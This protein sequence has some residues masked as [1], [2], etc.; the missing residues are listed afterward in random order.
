M[1]LSFSVKTALGAL[2]LVAAPL[3]AAPPT[4][5]A[6]LSLSDE[7]VQPIP[8]PEP[9]NARQ[10]AIVALGERL[11]ADPRLSSNDTTA[12]VTCHPLLQGGADR[13]RYSRR[14]LGDPTPVNTPTIFNLSLNF[15]L[16][17]NGRVR[18]LEEQIR[19]AH[20]VDADTRWPQVF[21][22]LQRDAAYLQ[23]FA[24]LFADGLTIAN[25]Q[26]AIVAFEKSLITSNSRFDRYLRGDTNA[27]TA[28]EAQGYDLFKTYGCAACHQGANVGG[29]L[30]QKFG[31]MGDYFKDRGNVTQ[32][33]VGRYN[34][35][36]H[37]D[38]RYVFRVPSLRLAVLTPPYL[39][40]GSA[41]TLHDAVKIMA[42]YQLGRPISDEHIELII[43]FLQ[44]LP[45][46]Y[47][48]NLLQAP[49]KDRG[50]P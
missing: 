44:T 24:M 8:I 13:Q 37:E 20:L 18:T 21:E 35:T 46:E 45:G 1:P 28:R 4:A 12:C 42:K 32:A 38:D 2:L 10:R 33:D 29:N 14:A 22:K 34:V 30:F 47:Q 9:L 7:P 19:T 41:A 17:W 11:F 48:G 6:M 15:R 31:V 39:H 27:I 5:P 3:L 16:F 26:D 50:E 36:G 40:D 25:I 49:E 43:G 23:N